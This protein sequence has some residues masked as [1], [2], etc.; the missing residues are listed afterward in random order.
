[1]NSDTWQIKADLN[2]QQLMTGEER[3]PVLGSLLN[4]VQAN[5]LLKRSKGFQLYGDCLRKAATVY[6]FITSWESKVTI[7]MGQLFVQDPDG[8]QYGFSYNPPFELHAWVDV[9]GLII[10]LALPGVI[11]RGK[12]MRDDHG[13]FLSN[14]EP[15]ILAGGV[16]YWLYYDARG[17]CSPEQAWALAGG[18]ND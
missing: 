10:D 13:F 1:M 11:L 15:V 16:P 14:T 3:Y 12:N 5:I 9:A 17:V 18:R 7:S 2:P 8:T 4:K 6:E